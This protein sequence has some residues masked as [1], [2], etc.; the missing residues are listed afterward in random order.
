VRATTLITGTGSLSEPRVPDIDGL[1]DFGGRLFHSARWD[2]DAEL[3]G[4]RV[5]VIGTGASAIQIVPELARPASHVDVH[6]RTAPYVI[7]RRDRSYTRVERLLLRHVPAIGRLYRSGVY[8]GRESYVP[9]FTLAP[10]LTR[11]AETAARMHRERAIAD[12]DLRRRLTPDYALGCKRVLISND[13]Y[14]T[15]AQDH[16]DLVTDRIVRVTRDAVVTVDADGTETARPVDVIV[17]ATGFH[18]TDPPVA[19]LVRG[20]DGRLLAD[21]WREHGMAAYKGTTVHGFPNLFMVVGPNTVLGHSSMVFVIESQVAYLTD[22]IRSMRA[23]GWTSVEP[24]RA[25]QEAYNASLQRRMRR[26]VWSTGGCASWYLDEHG[27]NTTLWPR[28]TFTMRARLAEFDPEAY[29]VTIPRR[30]HETMPG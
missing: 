23:A 11:P 12:P 24:T 8:W 26:T 21:Q 30:L 15:L 25:A 14:P 6:Q 5:A 7:P 19:D 18:A 2:H 10:W 3:A 17:V 9:A 28:A 1:T 29:A 13:Y 22:A 20:R 27:R 4:K 16:V